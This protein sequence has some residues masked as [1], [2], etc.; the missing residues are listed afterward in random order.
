[1]NDRE[2]NSNARV[3]STN[4]TPTNPSDCVCAAY[5]VLQLLLILAVLNLAIM[6]NLL[7]LHNANK[8]CKRFIGAYN[9]LPDDWEARSRYIKPMFTRDPPPFLTDDEAKDYRYQH[10]SE[11]NITKRNIAG[12]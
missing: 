8:K 4:I 12:A 11:Y 1:V 10:G 2:N 5:Y 6:A 7:R 9:D 3:L